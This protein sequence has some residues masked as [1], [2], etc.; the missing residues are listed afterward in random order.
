M[1]L[2]GFDKKKLRRINDDFE[3]VSAGFTA[4]E[5]RVCGGFLYYTHVFKCACGGTPVKVAGYWCCHDC[6][7]PGIDSSWWNIKVCR[8]GDAWCCIGEGFN[9]LQSSDNYAYGDTREDAIEV[10]G[11]MMRGRTT[12][13]KPKTVQ[14]MRA[15][16]V[17][18]NNRIYPKSILEQI[19]KQVEGRD[20]VEIVHGPGFYGDIKDVVGFARDIRLDDED[21]LVADIEMIEPVHKHLFDLGA[22][23]IIPSGGGKIDESGEVSEYNL[24]CFGAVPLHSSSFYG[25]VNVDE[26]QDKEFLWK[27]SILDEEEY[28]FM[29]EEKE[30][31]EWVDS[32][33]LVKKN[34]NVTLAPEIITKIVVREAG[35]LES[36]RSKDG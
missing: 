25:L 21:F 3:Q 17:N 32:R 10:Y 5:M 13:S 7:S 30:R 34:G 22:T 12:R 11:R 8:D 36:Q 16:V 27:V 6:G 33:P 29:T 4:A 24:N 19:V 18:G 15:D 20:R 28:F 14:I 26:N 1:C 2:D 35:W 9:D 31:G 23:A